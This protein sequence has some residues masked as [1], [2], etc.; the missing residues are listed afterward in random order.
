[1]KTTVTQTDKLEIILG[2]AIA[3]AGATDGILDEDFSK[4]DV[5]KIK[6]TINGLLSETA[7]MYVSEYFPER[8]AANEDGATGELA[9][10]ANKSLKMS[11]AFTKMKG[12][13]D[14]T[15]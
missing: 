3:S 11:I 2:L 1:M 13:G 14:D 7:T 9:I 4:E 8:C 10:M 5:A 6:A 15:E 12:D